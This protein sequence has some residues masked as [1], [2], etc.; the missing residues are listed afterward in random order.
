MFVPVGVRHVVHRTPI[1]NHGKPGRAAGV[2]LSEL[3]HAR[4][5]GRT[6]LSI[7]QPRPGSRPGHPTSVTIIVNARRKE[8]DGDTLTFEQLLALAFDP[9][10]S[11]PHWE[12]TVSYRNGPRQNPRGFMHPGD[13]VHIKEGMVFSVTATDKS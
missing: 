7:S 11:G 10:P 6:T 1:Q 4:V 8:V 5:D 13:T 12:F 2:W 9:V 3:C